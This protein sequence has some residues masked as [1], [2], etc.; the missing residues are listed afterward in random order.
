MWTAITAIIPSRASIIHFVIRSTPACR[1]IE[2]MKKPSTMT[3]AVAVQSITGS[4]S[5]PPNAASTPAGSSP[6]RPPVAYLAK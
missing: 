2:R 4:A 6:V 5:I 3:S 1:P